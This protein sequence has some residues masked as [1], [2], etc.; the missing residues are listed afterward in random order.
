MVNPVHEISKITRQNNPEALY[1]VDAVS[2]LAAEDIS[3]NKSKIDFCSSTSGKSIGGLPG[4][5]MICVNKEIV[6]SMKS[7]HEPGG[8]YLNL[9]N[10]YHYAETMNQT[11][12]TPAIHLINALN[13]AIKEFLETD[14]D[15]FK[16]QYKE[17]SKILFEGL[18]KLGIKPFLENEKVRSRVV[19]TFYL[20][21][22]KV[23]Y[24]TA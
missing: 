5:S 16:G 18:L 8:G 1:F 15:N 13:V 12:H 2:A 7:G 11:P 9:F 4:L 19:S 10:L 20:P 22:R 24:F 14:A 17:C 6:A 3:V 23:F 21:Y